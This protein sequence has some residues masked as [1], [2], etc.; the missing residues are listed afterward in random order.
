MC[1]TT[2]KSY[3]FQ[4]TYMPT[5]LKPLNAT[6]PIPYVKLHKTT[7]SPRAGKEYLSFQIYGRYSQAANCVKYRIMTKVINYILSIDTFEKQ[8]AVLKGVLQ[9]PRL[10]DHTKTIGIIQSA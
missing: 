9:S 10:K 7:K 2:K 3:S 5:H 4:A 1:N 8:Y 6:I